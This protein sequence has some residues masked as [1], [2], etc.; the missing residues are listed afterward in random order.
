MAKSDKGRGMTEEEKKRAK[1]KLNEM[2]DKAPDCSICHGS[3]K[4]EDHPK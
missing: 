2:I 1:R 4:T 3:H